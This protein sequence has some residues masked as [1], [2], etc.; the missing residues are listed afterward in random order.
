MSAIVGMRVCEIMFG[1]S[2]F[3][4]NVSSMDGHSPE[5]S[6][7]INISDVSKYLLLALISEPQ[8]HAHISVCVPRCFTCL[9]FG[10]DSSQRMY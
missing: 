8:L 7:G 3:G 1:I 9:F 6:S 5:D 2:D 4:F 10:R